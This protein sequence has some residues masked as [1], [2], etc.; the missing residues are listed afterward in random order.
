MSERV[1]MRE[2]EGPNEADKEQDKG[3]RVAY[4]AETWELIEHDE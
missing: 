3:V 1:L 4:T 2:E